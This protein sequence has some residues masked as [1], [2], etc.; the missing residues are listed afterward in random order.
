MGHFTEASKP[1]ARS[2][3]AT[4]YPASSGSHGH[5]WVGAVGRSSTEKVSAERAGVSQLRSS[6]PRPAVWC[7]ATTTSP[8]PA[9]ARPRSATSALVEPASSTTSTVEPRQQVGIGRGQPLGIEGWALRPAP[10]SH[11]LAFHG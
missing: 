5:E 6:R 2:A 11:A 10:G 3:L 9:P 4:A 1:A 7:S 8:W